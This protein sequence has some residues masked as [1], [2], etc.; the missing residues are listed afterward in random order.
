LGGR[1]HKEVD[2]NRH[3]PSVQTVIVMGW[4]MWHV[5]ATSRELDQVG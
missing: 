2:C 5:T 3:R 1:G 4:E